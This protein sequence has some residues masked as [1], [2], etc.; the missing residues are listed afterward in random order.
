MDEGLL[1]LHAPWS[2][3]GSAPLIAASAGDIDRDCSWEGLQRP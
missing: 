2:V 3:E 1:E